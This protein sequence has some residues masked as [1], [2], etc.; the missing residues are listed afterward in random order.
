M[1]SI[2]KSQWREGINNLQDEFSAPDKTLTGNKILKKITYRAK[3]DNF[4]KCFDREAEQKSKGKRAWHMGRDNAPEKSCNHLC[5]S[6][7][8]NTKDMQW[9]KSVWYQ[10]ILIF[11]LY[12]VNSSNSCFLNG[13]SFITGHRYQYGSM[14]RRTDKHNSSNHVALTIHIEFGAA[15]CKVVRIGPG[16]NITNHHKRA[17]TGQ[18]N[19]I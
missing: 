17:N 15:K 7:L 11:L 5:R 8:E 4:E 1:T 19:N 6:S 14:I 13:E 12:H 3:K 16:E 10:M 9:W 2:E 18:T